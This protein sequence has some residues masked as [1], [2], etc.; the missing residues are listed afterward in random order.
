MVMGTSPIQQISVL[1]NTAQTYTMIL[2]TQTANSLLVIV[3]DS[4]T[5]IALE[6]AAVHLEK[7]SPLTDYNG[8]TGG[9]VWLQNDWSG[10]SGQAD[11][12][13]PS[14]YFSDDGN[15]DLNS[16]PAGV[17]LSKVAGNYV[18]SGQLIS[19]TFDTGGASNFTTITWDPTSQNP[20]T[21][22]KFQLAS[23]N[24]DATWNYVGPDGTNATYYTV[25]GTNIASVHDNDRYIRYKALLSTSDNQQTPVLTSIVINYVAGCFTPGQVMFGGLTSASDY[26][27]D[28]SLSG[29]QPFSVSPLSISGNQSLQVLLSP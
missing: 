27:L 10:G 24:D 4:G 15:I 12:V 29:Y 22:L 18:S 1:P 20:S 11:F 21:T 5:G 3:K 26:S 17:R 25:S 2:G 7:A 6:N 23:N 13:N 14:R 19:S 28:V 8:L 16:V 9:S